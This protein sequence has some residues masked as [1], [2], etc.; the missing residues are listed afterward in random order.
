MMA[1]T[2]TVSAARAGH[3]APQPGS[4]RG[5]GPGPGRSLD[6]AQY[7]AG[8]YCGTRSAGHVAGGHGGAAE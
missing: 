4:A 1:E 6:R 8:L 2:T 7:P 3:R 5:H